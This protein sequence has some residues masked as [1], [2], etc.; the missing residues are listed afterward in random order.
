MLEGVP[1]NIRIMQGHGAHVLAAARFAR[2]AQLGAVGAFFANL[3]KPLRES[4]L[5]PMHF[6]NRFGIVPS[7]QQILLPT[8]GVH[9]SAGLALLIGTD[10]HN[11]HE[12]DGMDPI[13]AYMPALLLECPEVPEWA[14]L[15]CGTPISVEDCEDPYCRKITLSQNNQVIGEGDSDG[16]THSV[17]ALVAQASTPLPLRAGELIFTGAAAGCASDVL[18]LTLKAGDHL[19]VEIDG[20]GD[21]RVQLS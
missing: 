9:C 7:G 16:L 6:I 18:R 13:A 14:Y 11:A 21:A 12:D 19:K 2:R 1:E 17:A 5:A 20:L 15:V 4:K 3:F 8:E 10:C